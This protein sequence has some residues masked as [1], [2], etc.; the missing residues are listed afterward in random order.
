MPAL[1]E[2][3]GAASD[4]N[5][6]TGHH[7]KQQMMATKTPGNGLVARRGG[8]GTAGTRG[9]RLGQTLDSPSVTRSVGSWSSQVGT[10][11]SYW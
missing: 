4:L 2:A 7:F 1:W 3:R 11:Q 10:S 6:A 8:D 5:W 9:P